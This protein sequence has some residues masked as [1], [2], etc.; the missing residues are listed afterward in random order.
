MI[1][2][3]YLLKQLGF[4]TVIL[5]Y[6]GHAPMQRTLGAAMLVISLMAVVL[7]F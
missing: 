3:S 7:E 5:I 2:I 4:I 6:L 1:G